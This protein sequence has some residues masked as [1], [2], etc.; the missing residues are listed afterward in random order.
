MVQETNIKILD[1]AT[2]ENIT[3]IATGVH[4][5]YCKILEKNIVLKLQNN[6]REV[7]LL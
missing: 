6:V 1:Y 2:F 7:R 5:A 4:R 3:P